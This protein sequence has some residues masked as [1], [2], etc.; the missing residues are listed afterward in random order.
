MHPQDIRYSTS[1]PYEEVK[2]YSG[3]ERNRILKFNCKPDPGRSRNQCVWMLSGL[4]VGNF[5]LRPALECTAQ[6][7]A[8][9]N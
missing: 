1:N 2:F 7:V 4:V 5:R 9:T 8:K 3:P 6:S